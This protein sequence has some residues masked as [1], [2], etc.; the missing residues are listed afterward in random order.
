LLLS[1][2]QLQLPGPASWLFQGVGHPS[3]GNTPRAGSGP[4]RLTAAGQAVA[5]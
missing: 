3:E 1:N 5:H 4:A 2:Q